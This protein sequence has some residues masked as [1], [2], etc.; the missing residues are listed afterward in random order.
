[1]LN[2]FYLIFIYFFKVSKEYS[3]TSLIRKCKKVRI[4]FFVSWSDFDVVKILMF[5]YLIIFKI[6]NG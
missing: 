6:N 5:F 3:V 4:F 1:M 2:V